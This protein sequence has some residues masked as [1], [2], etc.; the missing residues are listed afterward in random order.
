MRPFGCECAES[1]RWNRFERLYIRIFGKVDLPTR[2]RSRLILKALRSIPWK[3]MIDFGCGTGAYSL[4]F[5]RSPGIRI[6]GIDT[7][8]D[9]VSECNGLKKKLKRES[10]A[11]FRGSRIFEN[12][13]FQPESVDLVLAVEVLQYMPDAQA[14]LLEIQQVLKPGGYLIGHIPVLGYLRE[15]EKVLFDEKKL[16]DWICEA[17][18]EP[19]SIR[20]VFGKTALFLCRIFACG[21]RSRFLTALAFPL[22]LLASLPCG[23]TSA[24]GSYCLVI[25]RKQQ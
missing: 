11:F 10:L 4:F 21:V 7:N 8:E 20:R 19:V 12:N 22:L 23:G 25:A 2:I 16:V 13:R 6:W 1:P 5:S 15:P 3:N 17:G 14:A 24:C 18:L 9:R